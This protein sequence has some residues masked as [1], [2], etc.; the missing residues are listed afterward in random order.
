MV[1]EFYFDLALKEAWLS[2]GITLPNPCVGAVITDERGAILSIQSHKEAGKPHA[3]VLALRDAFAKINGDLGILA[4]QDAQEIHNFL[5]QNAQNTF[6]NC[7]LYITLEP[8]IHEGQ[9]PSCAKL[10]S[11]LKPK[12]IFIGTKDPNEK[13]CGGTKM[14]E[15]CGIP[16][17][18][19]WEED[20]L[21]A[22][23]QACENLLLPFKIL[24]QKQKFL[25]YKYASRLDGSLEGG[26]ITQKLAQSF[27]HNIRSKVD[28]LLISGKTIRKD[29]PRLDCRFATLE[30]PKSP[31]I[32]V[33]TRQ[34]ELPK[35]SLVFTIPNR[36]VQIIREIS[37]LKGFVMIEGGNNLFQNLYHHIDLLLVFLNPSLRED[38]HQRMQLNANFKVLFSTLV[39]EDLLLWLLPLRD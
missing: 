22:I 23:H 3:E 31:D 12:K 36:K 35:D 29:N 25:L 1:E 26:Q 10:L 16:I 28:F 13:A 27:M 18:K 39:G 32:L 19:A 9:T 20:S 21:K 11:I 4:L 14:L 8:C 34:N 7:E 6:R 15:D 24:H 30:N 17:I 33:L 37:S 2:Q 5:L 38:F